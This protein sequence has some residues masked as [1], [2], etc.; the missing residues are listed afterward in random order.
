MPCG[1]MAYNDR[2]ARVVIDACNLVGLSIPSQIQVVG[3]NDQQEICENGK[4]RDT[5]FEKV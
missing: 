1:L 2:C 4:S 3:V 5:P